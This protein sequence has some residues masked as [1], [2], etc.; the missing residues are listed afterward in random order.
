MKFVWEKYVLKKHK[1]IDCWNI[2]N[3]MIDKYA[4]FGEVLSKQVKWY[5]DN[6]EDQISNYKDFIYVAKNKNDIIAFIICNVSYLDEY[7]QAGINPIVINPNLTNRGL[8]KKILI[9]FID[10]HE[11]LLGVDVKEYLVMVDGN[12]SIAKKLFNSVGFKQT[13]FDDGY[14]EYILE[15]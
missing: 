6:P 11:L 12:N 8:G 14:F 3:S 4:M 15:V 2:F 10:N 1:D 9:D 13:K 7:Y 5:I